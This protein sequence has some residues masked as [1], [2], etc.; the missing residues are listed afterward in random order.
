MNRWRR[1]GWWLAAVMALIRLHGAP[2]A[3]D[4]KQLRIDEQLRFADGL[5]GRGHYALA[6][7]EYQRLIREYPNDPLVADAWTQLAEAYAA[8][9]R[10]EQA[11]QLYDEFL[12]RFPN[13]ATRA[14]AETNRARLLLGSDQA[15][16]QAQGRRLLLEL[17]GRE[18]VPEVVREAAAYY[19]ARHLIDHKAGA[20]TAWREMR[21]LAALP[22]TDATRH[23]FRATAR[24]EVAGELSRQGQAAAALALLAP[25]MAD[26]ALPAEL[27][28]TALQM[29]AAIHWKTG[30]FAAAA[31]DYGRL[32]TLFPESEAGREAPLR[33]LEALYQAGD[34]RTLIREADLLLA[35]LPQSAGREQVLLLK[36]AGLELA[37]FQASAVE[38][39][40]ELLS[41]GGDRDRLRQAAERKVAC[42]RQDNQPDAAI[43]AVN[44]W[45]RQDRLPPEVLADLTILAA[46]PPAAPAAAQALLQ[47][48]VASIGL[49][50]ARARVG[51][52]LAATLLGQGRP[53]EA[54]PHYQTVIAAGVPELGDFARLGAASCLQALGREQEAVAAYRQ[55][56]DSSA[57][58]TEPA[59]EAT[60]RW[61]L[62]LLRDPAKRPEAEA[63]FTQL[64]DR[65]PATT[66]ATSASFYLGYLEF[67]RG[68][69]AAAERRLAEL[70][71]QQNLPVEVRDEATVYLLWT[72]LEQGRS[73]EVC[74]ALS[75]M[76]QAEPQ[77]A[78][79]PGAFLVRAGEACVGTDP[80]LAL[81]LFGRV[82]PEEREL[83]Q[84]ALL[85]R[86][87]LLARG[88]QTDA[89]FTALREAIA[90]AA[91]P[92]TTGRARARLGELLVAA[93][94]PEQALIVFEEVISN[95]ASP[96]AAARA[97]LGLARILAQQEDRL[98]AANRQAMAV[99]I[100]STDPQLCTEAMLLSIQ[101]SLRLGRKDEAAST[102][103]E[104]RQR[105]PE[106]AAS[107]AG[108]AAATALAAAG[109]A[110]DQP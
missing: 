38:T 29:T 2:V 61:G 104:L 66:A 98:A 67:A 22:V 69:Y 97:R 91:E 23:R 14:A 88:G 108:R 53:A 74:R 55:L 35:K 79:W 92:V 56:A 34:G 52:Q 36:G 77:P 39:Y 82:N 85:G 42:L 5:L 41:S 62:L 103:R 43:A 93:G 17:K 11:L 4:Q 24:T 99:F 20:K 9:G 101:L 26:D 107:D 19:L 48:A 12:R 31:D 95:P 71:K 7:E 60:L 81:K 106:A 72:V 59:A 80:A 50:A 68:D 32:A 6:I 110:T 30:D 28:N 13:A 78:A 10:R 8:Q 46:A 44:E 51:L 109:V 49:P 27:R 25:L 3:D 83:R 89:A 87:E 40:T 15:E 73:E 90:L 45:L 16:A 21:K 102:W 64:L 96:D 37:G 65:H 86:G 63:V 54:L 94:K 1:V 100:L 105:F 33:R 75:K 57:T 58:A 70:L 84:R 18:D 47:E 76:L